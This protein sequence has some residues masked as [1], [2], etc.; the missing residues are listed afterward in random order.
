MYFSGNVGLCPSSVVQ[1]AKQDNE[2]LT[3]IRHSCYTV[4]QHSYSW[5]HAESECNRRGGHL[6]HVSDRLENLAIYILLNTHFNHSVWMGLSDLNQEEH[7]E[8]TSS[9]KIH[10]CYFKGFVLDK[11]MFIIVN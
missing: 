2:I 9:K 10:A 1:Y 7:F 3:Q 6:F 11:T 5:P 8:W 4:V